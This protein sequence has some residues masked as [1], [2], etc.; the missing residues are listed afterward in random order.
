MK[1]LVLATV[2]HVASTN[3][4][5]RATDLKPKH[6]CAKPTNPDALRSAIPDDADA[7]PLR[8]SAPPSLN[9]IQG[10]VAK[11]KARLLRKANTEGAP[12]VWVLDDYVGIGNALDA[13]VRAVIEAR[14]RGRSLVIKSPILRNLCRIVGVRCINQIVA[15]RLRQRTH[16][17]HWLICAQVA[18][19]GLV[20]TK[21]DDLSRTERMCLASSHQAE[22]DHC[23]YYTTFGWRN[24]KYPPDYDISPHNGLTAAR[25]AILRE[26][27]PR[28][29]HGELLQRF[30]P[31]LEKAFVGESVEEAVAEGS[32]YAVALHLRTLDF[33]EGKNA[34]DAA[35]FDW[36]QT[37][38]ARFKWTCLV[39]RLRA[40]GL[41]CS[42]NQK[43]FLAAVAS[44]VEINQ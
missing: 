23:V 38:K 35:A 22:S 42:P 10:S 27:L 11:Q 26:F 15:A 40:L 14:H 32:R 4:C 33:I 19:E 41:G 16:P 13:Y 9:V 2:L 6:F 1:R 21:R 44:W 3:N 28:R 30:L 8:G 17:T 12:L 37:R 18:C 20:G 34:T 5:E 31:V 7:L 29:E 39:R 25:R 43:V 24:G 36:L